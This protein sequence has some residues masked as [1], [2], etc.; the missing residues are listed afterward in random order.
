MKNFK[1]FFLLIISAAVLTLAGCAKDGETGPAGKDGANGLN[2]NANVQHFSFSINPGDWST[3]GTPGNTGH[4]LYYERNIPE[5]TQDI[6]DNGLVKTY[7][8]TGGYQIAL[9]TIIYTPSYQIQYFDASSVGTLE[10]DLLLSNL[11]T[12]TVS[13]SFSFKCIIIDGT[14][15]A[16]NPDIDWNNYNQVKSRLNIAD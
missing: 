3:Y 5:I 14:V 9:P 7:I 1:N 6:I 13:G 4:G 10:I 11:A 15:R 2:G 16:M 12:P 8:L